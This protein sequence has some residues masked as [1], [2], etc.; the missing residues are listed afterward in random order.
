MLPSDLGYLFE[1]SVALQPAQPD[2]IQGNAVVSFEQL[3]A[4]CNQVAN[5]LCGLGVSIGDRVAIMCGNDYRFLEM[6]F[7]TIRLGAVPVLINIRMGDDAVSHIV[8]DSDSVVIMANADLATRALAVSRRTPNIKHLICVGG[9]GGAA[10]DYESLMEAQVPSFPRRTVSPDDICLQPYTS[11]STGRPKGVLLS[12]R[13]QIWNADTMRKVSMV[14]HRD[15]ALVAVPLF[16]KNAMVAAVKPF[17]LAGGTLVIL[18]EFD[19]GKVVAAIEQSQITYITGT[20]AM[21]KLVLQHYR[22]SPHHDVS[23]LRFALCGSAVVSESLLLEFQSVFRCPLVEIYGLTEGGVPVANTRGG[24]AKRGSCGR[25]VPG[26]EVRI[27]ADD[28]VVELGPDQIGE[29]VI[30]NP[31]LASGYWK[32]PAEA[33]QRFKDGWL[34]TGDLMKQDHDGFH[35]FVGRKDDMINVSGEK[36]YPKEV[37]EVLSTHPNVKDVV[38]VPAAHPL[39]GHVPVAFVVERSKGAS[40]DEDIKNFFLQRGAPYAHPRKV[41]FVDSLPVGG[42]GKVDRVALQRL[43]DDTRETPA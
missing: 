42:T 34:F 18:P 28:G 9:A 33:A 15:R 20:P 41:H 27:V 31:A 16:H 26:S 13:S 25:L 37:E 14:D 32:R 39:K 12:H 19:A 29:L 43:A 35:Y 7:G 23:S 17:L 4:R 8:A 21:Y 24:F 1:A 40:S 10:I 2:V 36:V 38:V 5:A 3:D 6:V 11:G 22:D 30:R